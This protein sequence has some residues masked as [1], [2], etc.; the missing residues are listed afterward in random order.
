MPR[1]ALLALL[2]LAACPAASDPD[3]EP[4]DAPTPGDDDDATEPPPINPW[5]DEPGDHVPNHVARNF[6]FEGHNGTFALYDDWTGEDSYVFIQHRNNGTQVFWESDL[7]ELLNWSPPNVHYFFVS[8]TANW[9]ADHAY[10]VQAINDALAQMDAAGAEYGT[11]HWYD[12]LH[13]ATTHRSGLSGQPR[14]VLENWPLSTGPSGG[15]SPNGFGID[16][17]QRLRE[18]GLTR[19]VS[20]D[21]SAPNELWWYAHMARYY[22]YEYERELFLRDHPADHVT[23][24]WEERQIAQDGR[25]VDVELP[26]AEAMAGFDTL[27]VDLTMGCE[28][29]LDQNCWEWDYKAHMTVCEAEQ[30]SDVPP[31]DCQ[32]RVTD[33]VTG[34]VV[35][36]ADT[37]PCNCTSPYGGDTERDR[38]CNAVTD[39]DGEI[40]GSEWSA[41]RCTCGPE[42]ARWITSYHR[43]GRWLTD[44]TPSLSMLQGGGPARFRFNTSY[45]YFV[46]SELRFSNR[47]DEPTAFE[48]KQLWGGGNFNSG[49]NAAHQPKKF[50]VPPGTVKAEVVA[51]IT[52]HGFNGDEENCA[53]F[54]AHAHHFRLNG[55]AEHVREHPEAD[56]YLGCIP[57]IDDGAVPNQYGTWY[58][59]RGGWCPGLDVPPTRFD[60]TDDLD[61]DGFNELEYWGSLAGQEP[62]NHGSIW[63]SSYL[64]FYR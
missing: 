5:N 9:E 30:P 37:F 59:G 28:G 15:W 46:S 55:G 1:S 31:D 8:A 6:I 16:R 17:F 12:R 19:F 63:M 25:F 3:P 54:C 29:G 24:L 14:T 43:D 36:E 61:F 7:V 35:T 34:E 62:D 10:M 27:E 52:G 2:L 13:V 32:P 53:E 45:N 23:T 44:I 33:P 42:I 60:V 39:E 58:L 41:C 64:V 57:Q 49:Y 47:A 22:N 4:V 56:D 18:V 11:K 48:Y 50:V 26:D 40:V 20:Q 38:V 21:G 51:F